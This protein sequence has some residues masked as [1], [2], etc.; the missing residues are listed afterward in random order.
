V[1]LRTRYYDP[2]TAQFLSRDPLVDLTHQPYAYVGDNPLNGA[3]PSGLYEY[4][5]Q[6]DLGA[7]SASRNNPVLDILLLR[8]MPNR[9]F[10]ISFADVSG[11]HPD[12]DP[13]LRVGRTYNVSSAPPGTLVGALPAP[14]KVMGATLNSFTIEALSGHPEGAGSKIT[15]RRHDAQVFR[16]YGRGP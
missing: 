1:Y 13:L 2:E 5:Y 16:P 15:F 8:F 12:Y 10:P 6:Q 14:L 9:I 3:D 7:Y 4:T 11:D